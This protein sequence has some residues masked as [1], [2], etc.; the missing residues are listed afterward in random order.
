MG[1]RN[2]HGGIAFVYSGSCS[3][4]DMCSRVASQEY[5]GNAPPMRALPLCFIERDELLVRLAKANA[6][7]THPH[8]KARAA[9][10]GI[11]LAGRY[12]IMNRHPAENIISHVCNALTKLKEHDESMFDDETI[13]YL[14]RV[15]ML[16]EPGPLESG[17]AHFLSDE[18]R[19]QLCGPQ[20][21]WRGPDG[22][23]PDKMPRMV[24]GLGADAQRTLGCVLYLLKFHTEGTQMQTLLRSVYIGGDVDSLAALCLAMVGGREGLRIGLPGGVPM[25]CFKMLESAEYVI[26]VADKFEQWCNEH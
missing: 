13:S 17:H 3:I 9:S 14:K 8:V 23:P 6:D 2:G 21:I 5:P 15:D 26:E 25:Y 24:R 16:P 7:S 11:A 18:A 4:E 22:S 10:L 20:P 1:G 19:T 12:F